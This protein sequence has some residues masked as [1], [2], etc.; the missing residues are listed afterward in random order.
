MTGQTQYEIVRTKAEAVSFLND[1]KHARLAIIR[2]Q[3]C[4]D[5][6]QAYAKSVNIRAH[7]AKFIRH[8]GMMNGRSIQNA[9]AQSG[10]D[11]TAAFAAAISIEHLSLS[12]TYWEI[13]RAANF[14]APVRSTV[15]RLHMMAP[16]P[17]RFDPEWHIDNVAFT[18]IG[19]H[20]FNGTELALIEPDD[21]A[22]WD[23]I[24]KTSDAPAAFPT[25]KL[26]PGDK[27]FLKGRFAHDNK[28]GDAETAKTFAIGHRIAGNAW[29]TGYLSS[30]VAGTP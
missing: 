23:H 29:Q 15:S 4:A 28:S 24:I 1:G 20:A 25:I 12:N 7:Q 19:A 21:D 27:G 30:F 10:L 16:L 11:I 18:A 26:E 8:S 13:S 22:A 2:D 6:A 17:K 5:E 3:K 9:A 14:C